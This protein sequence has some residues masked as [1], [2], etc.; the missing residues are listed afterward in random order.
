MARTLYICYFGVREPLVNYRSHGA[1][2]HRNVGDMERGMG[3]FYEKAFAVGGDV[4]RLRRRALGNYNRVLA[5]SYFRAGQYGDFFRTA[6]KSIWYRPSGIGYF[7]AFPL[8]R[9]R[10]QRIDTD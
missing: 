7:A 8:R 9:F 4:L 3:L 10:K 2:A 1:A 5:G 6:A